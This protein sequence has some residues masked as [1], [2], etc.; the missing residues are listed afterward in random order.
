MASKKNAFAKAAT[1]VRKTTQDKAALDKAA[2]EGGSL[3]ANRTEGKAVVHKK[4][5]VRRRAYPEEYAHLDTLPRIVRCQCRKILDNRGYPVDVPRSECNCN[6]RDWSRT[7]MH[8][9]IDALQLL[10]DLRD[11]EEQIIGVRIPLQSYML[12]AFTGYMPT[13]KEGVEHAEKLQLHMTPDEKPETAKT[14]SRE[15]RWPKSLAKVCRHEAKRV[16]ASGR[17]KGQVLVPASWYYSE[18]IRQFVAARL[19]LLRA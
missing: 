2:L 17:G 13:M 19:S 15:M 16:Y 10:E 3:A 9:D 6:A 1:R 11:T 4:A 18:A 5:N 8:I 14:L 12:A 7:C